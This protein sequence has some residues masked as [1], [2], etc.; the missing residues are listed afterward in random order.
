MTMT[1]RSGFIEFVPWFVSL[2][3]EAMSKDLS[4]SQH[5]ALPSLANYYHYQEQGVQQLILNKSVNKPISFRR[6]M[7]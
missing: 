4:G 6:L 2:E 3:P 1:T 7:G 5:L